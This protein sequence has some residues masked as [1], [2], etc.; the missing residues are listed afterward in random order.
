MRPGSL[1]AA[2]FV[3]TLV[4]AGAWF[5]YS[6][7]QIAVRFRH[8][9]THQHVPRR[10]LDE[11]SHSSP[12]EVSTG[13]VLLLQ[14]TVAGIGRT[15]YSREDEQAIQ[16][17]NFGKIILLGDST[18]LLWSERSDLLRDDRFVSRVIGGHTSMDV[19]LRTEQDAVALAP[20]LVV[21]QVGANDVL[22]VRGTIPAPLTKNYITSI[23]DILKLHGIPVVLAT[24]PPTDVVPDGDS[25]VR[26]LN[27]WIKEIA[28][29]RSIQVADF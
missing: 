2:A 16:A 21:L 8:D 25:A 23:L 20:R 17:R 22:G 18:A 27:S 3:L 11:I 6:G 15:T 29:S 24:I 14:Q 10:S 9:L 13:E 7:R 4:S 26:E 5:A 19:L 12:A 28:A 1:S